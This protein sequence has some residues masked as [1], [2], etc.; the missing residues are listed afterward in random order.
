MFSTPEPLAV[1]RF[2]PVGYA[3]NH[4]VDLTYHNIPF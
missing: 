2:V 1:F 4:V 3:S